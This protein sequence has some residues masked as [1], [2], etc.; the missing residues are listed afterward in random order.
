MA[1]LRADAEI[2]NRN[3]ADRGWQQLCDPGLCFENPEFKGLLAIWRDLSS[4]DAPPARSQMTPRRLKPY[5][6]RLVISERVEKSPPRYRFR[7]MGMRIVEVLG[8]RTGKFFDDG[9]TALQYA[10]WTAS[11]ELV[12]AHRQPMRLIGHA[13]LDAQNHLFSELLFLPLSDDAGE[14]RFVMGFGHYSPDRGAWEIAARNI[15]QAMAS[16]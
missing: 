7:L 3:A 16:A 15:R 1:N 2:F 4:D 5:L 14:A 13:A 9:T 10:R 11:H 12:L 6:P 8:E